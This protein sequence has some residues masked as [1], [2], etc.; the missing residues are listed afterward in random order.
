VD[1]PR[2]VLV[3]FIAAADADDQ[4][5][6][7]HL[8]HDAEEL[9][10][11]GVDYRYVETVPGMQKPDIGL[12]EWIG[13]T[14]AAGRTLRELLQLAVEWAQRAKCPVRVRIRDDVIVLDDT[15]EDQRN[16]LIQGFIDRHR[17][18]DDAS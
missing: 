5:L 13:V 17:A 2:T 12:I 9:E 14:L 16:T 1:E 7:L 6:L 8:G 15:S 3:Q 18:H 4:A 10:F 11:G